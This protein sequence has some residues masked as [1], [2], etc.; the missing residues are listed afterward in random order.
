MIT[1]VNSRAKSNL[2]NHKALLSHCVIQTCQ[3]TMHLKIRSLVNVKCVALIRSSGP[4]LMWFYNI[5]IIGNNVCLC[6]LQTSYVPF[7]H[8]GAIHKYGSD[9]SGWQTHYDLYFSSYRHC[10]EII[11][12]YQ[13]WVM[14]FV[15]KYLHVH[16]FLVGFFFIC[17]NDPPMNVQLR[18]DCTGT[19]WLASA[20]SCPTFKY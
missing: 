2:I 15:I 17:R 18:P 11:R 5:V 1:D 9:P 14:L 3:Y 8:I 20:A 6:G 7:T 4:T 19:L 13:T 10:L 12:V 16:R